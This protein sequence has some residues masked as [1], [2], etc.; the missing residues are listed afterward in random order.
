MTVVYTKPGCPACTLT[1]KHLEKRGIPF[2]KR[3][4]TDA[5]LSTA[6]SLGITAAPIVETDGQPPWGG[7]R[8]DALD[9]LAS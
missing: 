3:P 8:P 4:I 5:V 1:V 7:Y 2:E 9:A 6:A